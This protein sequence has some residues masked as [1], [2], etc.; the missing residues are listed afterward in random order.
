MSFNTSEA[1][2]W[3]RR[4][5]LACI[6]PLILAVLLSLLIALQ[7]KYHWSQVGEAV[8]TVDSVLKNLGDSELTAIGSFSALCIFFYSLVVVVGSAISSFP[9]ASIA[10][11]FRVLGRRAIS[12]SVSAITLVITLPTYFWLWKGGEGASIDLLNSAVAVHLLMCFCAL[13]IGYVAALAI[14]MWLLVLWGTGPLESISKEAERLDETFGPDRWTLDNSSISVVVMAQ[15]LLLS[16]FAV[17]GPTPILK[18]L[19]WSVPPATLWLAA[20]ASALR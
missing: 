20:R 1:V 9:F 15:V 16:L 17:A 11:G 18:L 6:S 12:K 8:D 10:L 13:L 4:L 2:L 3:L 19:L 14:T 5:G 7:A